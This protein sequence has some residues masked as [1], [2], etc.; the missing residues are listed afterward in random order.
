MEGFGL[1]AI[2]KFPLSFLCISI[3]LC[4]G[5]LLGVLNPFDFSLPVAVMG[6][7]LSEFIVIASG[8]R[9]LRAF[10]EL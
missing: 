3:L 4:M 7:E 8:L 1:Q 6:H 10:A 2:Q 9:M 5:S